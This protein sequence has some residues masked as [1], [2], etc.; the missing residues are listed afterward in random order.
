[1]LE[2]PAVDAAEPEDPP[3]VPQ[4]RTKG[5]PKSSKPKPVNNELRVTGSPLTIPTPKIRGKSLKSFDDTLTDLTK[6]KS[7]TYTYDG[8]DPIDT[9]EWCD[10]WEPCYIEL[11]TDPLSTTMFDEA[12]AAHNSK[13]AFEVTRPHTS[14]NAACKH[15]GIPF[16]FHNEYHLWLVV[17][18]EIDVEHI[19]R[20]RGTYLKQGIRLPKPCGAKW[21]A[22]I[23]DKLSN[24]DATTKQRLEK[25]LIEQA[26]QATL[27]QIRMEACLG[28]SNLPSYKAMNKARARVKSVRDKAIAQGQDVPPANFDEAFN[29][30]TM[31]HLWVDAAY[32]EWEG[33][34]KL[35]VI[36]HGYTLQEVREMGIPDPISMSVGF[37]I[38]T[39]NNIFDRCKVRCCL[40]GHSGN[41]K[42]GIHYEETSLHPP[43][44]TQCV[45]YKPYLYR[46]SG[47]AKVLTSNKHTY[48]LH[49]T[50]VNTCQSNTQKASNNFNGTNEGMKSWMHRVVEFHYMESL[51]KTYM[52]IQQRV[53]GGTS[54]EIS[55]SSQTSIVMLL[56]LT[57]TPPLTRLPS[58]TDGPA[59]D[60]LWT[61]ACSNSPVPSSPLMVHSRQ[62]AS[63]L[64]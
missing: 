13:H 32:D 63:R 39:K 60:P 12:D 62:R 29:H 17:N 53:V 25:E 61:L 52:D 58:H 7:N 45:S 9:Q 57:L 30:P 34:T 4:V 27:N 55:L 23:A 42:K 11:A 50:L 15:H 38:K 54:T 43:I 10:L 2:Q 51:S 59:Y 41:M 44:N 46:K 21:R 14:F 35:G 22:I 24:S 3:E 1:M 28:N 8:R 5:G 49:L 6:Q 36:K 48:M 19:P 56:F 64:L 20:D 37:V 40:A 31:S 47:T 16:E 26:L 18:T 33:L